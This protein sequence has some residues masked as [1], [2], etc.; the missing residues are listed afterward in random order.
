[1]R[2]SVGI[3]TRG[4]S[5]SV[6]SRPNRAR[7]AIPPPE[8]ADLQQII[9]TNMTSPTRK[10][11]STA[12]RQGWRFTRRLDGLLEAGRIDREAWENAESGGTDEWPQE[13]VA[14]AAPMV[15]R[16]ARLRVS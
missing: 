10:S 14:V 15:R 11:T 6:A 1:M 9:S 7:D 8:Q 12:F 2:R 16:S 4:F 13:R 5:A 3:I